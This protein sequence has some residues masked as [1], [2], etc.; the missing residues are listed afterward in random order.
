MA[1]VTDGCSGADINR[2]ARAMKRR[3]ALR[4]SEPTAPM[5]FKALCDI[6]AREP[7][8]RTAPRVSR[9]L[10]NLEAFSIDALRDPLFPVKQKPLATLIGVNQGTVSRWLTRAA[11]AAG[12]P[13]AQ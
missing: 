9:L 13:H 5:Q 11:A 2:F 3:I 7:P 12:E 10:D 6:L 1:Y 8:A 4:N